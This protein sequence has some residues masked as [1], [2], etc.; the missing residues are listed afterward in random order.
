[1]SRKKTNN[2]TG[3]RPFPGSSE[4]DMERVPSIIELANPEVVLT[5]WARKQERERRRSQG[6]NPFAG[7][8]PGSFRVSGDRE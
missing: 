2:G 3:P 5:K 4:Q 7:A 6:G 1:M 8:I